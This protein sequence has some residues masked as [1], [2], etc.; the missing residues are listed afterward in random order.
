ML[1][2]P[3][4]FS[5]SQILNKRIGPRRFICLIMTGFGLVTM[6]TAFNTTYGGIITCRLMLGVFEAGRTS[7]GLSEHNGIVVDKS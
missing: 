3:S 1:A 2:S 5:P 7:K 6:C 4:S